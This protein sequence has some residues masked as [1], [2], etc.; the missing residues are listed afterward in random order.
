MRKNLIA[1]LGIVVII[2]TL[3]RALYA[4]TDDVLK[5]SMKTRW[6]DKVGPGKV[7]PEYPR[8]Q[9]TRANY[10]ILNG[11][12]EYAIQPTEQSLPTKFQGKI[13]V[14]FPVE[15][16][17]SGV[18]KMV[19]EK[20]YLWY[21]HTFKSPRLAKNK[22][23]LLHFG[24]VDWE[25]K[26][27]VN[28]KEVGEHRGGFDAFSFDI[29]DFLLKDEQELV[30]R[31]WDPSDKGTQPRGKQV[32]EP[33]GI[34]YTPVTGIWQT[35]WLEIVPENHIA[36]ITPVPDIDSRTLRVTTHVMANRNLKLRLTAT[37][38][39]KVVAETTIALSKQNNESTAVLSIP[40]PRLWSPA[41][42]F[43]YDL[44]AELLSEG[45]I[46]DQVG[47]Y[48]GMRKVSLGKDAKG[49]T[50]IML[51]NQALFQCGPLDQGW[52]PDGLYTPPSEEA[53]LYDI[54]AT[55]KMGFNML[56]KHVKV[57]CA[58]YYYH[59][60]KM[61]MLVWQDMPNGNYL[62][63]LRIEAW[64]TTDAKRPEASSKQFELELKRMIDQRTHFASI[65]V[66]VPFNEGWGQYDTERV[67]DWVK[68]YDSSR[69]VDSPSGWTDRGVGDVIDVHIYP[70]PGMEAAEANRAAVLGEFGGLGYPEQNHL[71]WDKRNWGYLTYTDKEKF[72]R[73]FEKLFSGLRGL[74]ANGLSAAIYTQTTDVEGEIN[75]LITY[76][77][78]VMKLQHD[79]V[80]EIVTPLYDEYWN[81]Y[82]Y[83]RDSEH[84]SNGW[85]VT[86]TVPTGNWMIDGYDDF[87]WASRNMPLSSFSNF[88]LGNNGTPWTEK[89]LF[90]RKE[91]ETS[92]L[93][94][95]LYLKHYMPG[96][97]AQVYLNG[98]LLWEHEDKG[99]RKRHYTDIDISE[100]KHLMRKGKNVLSVVL[101]QA[102]EKASF[103]IGVYTTDAV[104]QSVTS[105]Q[106]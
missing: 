51:N 39:G 84:S 38:S 33:Q 105:S 100:K 36:S 16:Q 54:E 40:N 7:W 17:L 27:F 32:A 56:R 102:N 82:F 81:A 20:N 35:V 44:K 10:V 11:S 30:V 8:P 31:V 60:D 93:P 104:K 89:E 46:E 5:Y 43:L 53:M 72:T 96:A 68:K 1:F 52:W 22:R 34:W 83:V 77:R 6:S 58:R 87:Q 50:R 76:D 97:K 75:G 55:R 62:K 90:L 42:P 4:Q 3:S 74:V 12:W 26:I 25:A 37:S 23:L 28:G 88:S 14:P 78:E 92:T 9:M 19:G 41:D 70:G 86:A 79:K 15:S 103:D 45:K 71:W 13:L 94:E 59:C 91:F 101:T 64:D 48:F 73:E 29:T 99:G 69:L 49:Y 67:T 21:K 61:G 80:R 65:L 98:E 63:E 66:W 106:Q 95:K 2:A 18:K 47:S 24:A 85:K 57:E